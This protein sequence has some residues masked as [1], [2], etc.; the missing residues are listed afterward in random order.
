MSR[1]LKFIL[2]L[3][4]VNVVVFLWP[5]TANVAPHAYRGKAEVN[6]HFVR[7]N[8]E[9][10]SRFYADISEDVLISKP[11]G[12]E[13][14]VDFDRGIDIVSASEAAS[15]AVSG[16]EGDECY[17]LGPF[18]YQES[19]ELAQAVLFNADVQFTKRSRVSKESDVFRLY[20][21]PFSSSAQ[22]AESRLELKQKKILDHFSRKLDD[23]QYII[24]LGIYSS[25]ESADSAVRLF[26]N[27]LQDVK[28]QGER[29]VLPDSYWLHFELLES[30]NKVAQLTGINWGENSV[31][32]S[33]DKCLS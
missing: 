21:G 10:E 20:L 7:L 11:A 31:K 13:L 5:S 29:V 26:S 16:G 32:M 30:S 6:P 28:V 23:G 12:D 33:P 1:L 27:K 19:Y 18:A 15:V 17:Q 24:S 25:Q 3:I 2:L 9:I 8:Q 22:V 4:L 14:V